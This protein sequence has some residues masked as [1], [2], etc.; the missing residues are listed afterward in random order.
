MNAF[1]FAEDIE[2]VL[3]WVGEPVILYGH[4]AGAAG[5]IIAASR[6]ADRIK[7]LFL[8][9]CYA[10]TREA[11]SNL[12]RWYKPFFGKYFAPMVI[13][14]MNL[15]YRGGLDRVNPARLAKE[16][17]MPVML[18]HGEKDQRFPLT[19]AETLRDSFQPGVAELFVAKGARHS[20]SSETPGYEGALKAF[21]DKHLE[22][23]S[24]HDE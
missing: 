23:N 14:W 19:Y 10:R 21:L 2:A 5:A 6:N 18:I 24:A 13:F 17:R 11:L 1:K 12:Y 20:G 16:I 9:A 8:E 15:F 22:M 7:L 3:D 4:S